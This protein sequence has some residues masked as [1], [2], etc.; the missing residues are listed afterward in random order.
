MNDRDCFTQIH[1]NPIW[2]KFSIGEYEPYSLVC[3]EK[4]VKKLQN[5]LISRASGRLRQEGVKLPGYGA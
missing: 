2:N 5:E 4:Q 1:T 3:Q